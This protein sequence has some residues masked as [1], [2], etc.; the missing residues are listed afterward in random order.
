MTKTNGVRPLLKEIETRK[1]W[2]SNSLQKILRRYPKKDK[3]LYRKDELVE[4]YKNLVK[5]GDLEKSKTIEQRIRLKPTRTQSGV[6]TVTV[7]M[8]PYPC[9]GK[10]IYCPDVNNMPKSYIPSEPGAQRAL[11]HQFDPYDQ[12]KYRIQ[13]LKNVGHNTDKIELIILGGTFSVYPKNYQIWFIKRCF[14]AMNSFDRNYKEGNID[15]KNT[16]WQDLFKAQDFNE[17]A[18]C[19]NV[20]L[21]LETRP[22]FITKEEVVGIR[23]LGATKVQIGVQSLNNKILK[24]NKRGHT[25]KETKKAFKL[26]RLAGF[27]IHAHIM[28]NL[29]GSNVKKDVEDYKK[30]WTKHYYP[31]EL[32]IYPTSILP[33]TELEKLYQEGKFHPY[34]EQELLEYFVNT[35]PTTPRS[36]RLTRIVRDIPSDEIVAGNKKT[37]FRQIAENEIKK[38]GLRIEDIRSREIKDEK[39]TW[40][41]IEQEIIKYKTSVSTE[42]FISYITKKDD[43]IC[44]FLRL[45]LPKKK[46]SKKHFIDELKNCAIIREVHVYGTLVSIGKKSK[47]EAQHLG[48][49]KELIKK[50]ESISKENGFK[51]ISVI[52][53]IGTRKY[54]EKRGFKRNELY[55]N[56]Y[57]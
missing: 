31:D 50:A 49:G 20:G 55:M 33:N 56:K 6:A 51:E 27:K 13:A 35:L 2:D 54:Y 15:E 24:L 30:L 44:G 39:I 12:T 7:L 41:D 26:L 11:A 8:K 29:Y 32:K 1:K 47:G 57:L 37:N 52:S 17:T 19:R 5:S 22:D 45:S 43:K 25:I 42:Y 9:P 3:G 21:V 40:D 10:C 18:E 4:A 48:L 16:T 28:P 36:V 46:L 14:D 34:S 23:K 38:L 53:A